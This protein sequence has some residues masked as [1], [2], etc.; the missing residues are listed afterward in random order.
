MSGSKARAC[1]SLPARW[2]QNQNRHAGYVYVDFD[3]AKIDVG[4]Y[5]EQAKLAV[6]TIAVVEPPAATQILETAAQ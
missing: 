6:A 1:G 5:V 2:R 4:R 3:T